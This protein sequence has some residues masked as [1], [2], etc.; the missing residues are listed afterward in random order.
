MPEA[1]KISLAGHKRG[2]E[3]PFYLNVAPFYSNVEVIKWWWV[4]EVGRG[5]CEVGGGTCEVGKKFVEQDS[6]VNF[7]TWQHLKGRDTN[8]I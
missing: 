4:S 7:A 2:N 1:G 5:T 6:R 8:L 3:S